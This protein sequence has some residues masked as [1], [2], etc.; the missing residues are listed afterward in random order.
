MALVGSTKGI[1]SKTFVIF[2][3]YKNCVKPI[4]F[5][6]FRVKFTSIQEVISPSKTIINFNDGL[7]KIMKL[8]ENSRMETLPVVKNGKYIGLVTKIDILENYRDK[9]KEMIIE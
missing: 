2:L 9:L 5:N 7:E 6:Q 1:F 3:E 4:L 8:F